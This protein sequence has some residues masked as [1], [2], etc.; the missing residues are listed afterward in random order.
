MAI[1]RRVRWLMWR[2]VWQIASYSLG[3][4]MSESL[5]PLNQHRH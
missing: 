2:A 1:R 4:W 3:L 5:G